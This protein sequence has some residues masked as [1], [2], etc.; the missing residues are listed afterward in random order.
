[1][2][3]LINGADNIVND[4]YKIIGIKNKNDDRYMTMCLF[5]D[6]YDCTASIIQND[7]IH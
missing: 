1:M 2:A 7:L 6:F 3:F 4:I 5:Y